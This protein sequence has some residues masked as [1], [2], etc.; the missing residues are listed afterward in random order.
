LMTPVILAVEDIPSAVRAARYVDTVALLGT[1]C[2]T[3]YATEISSMYRH[4]VWALDEDAT[5]QALKLMRKHALL[6]E[7]SRVLV[8]E[9]DLK[10]MK[11]ERLCELL[12]K[13]L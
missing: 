9:E 8:L 1:G 10:D 13:N 4:I 12:K 5:G 7:T 11:E 3:D 6:F 2:N